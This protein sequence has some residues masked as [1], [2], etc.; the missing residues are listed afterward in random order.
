[1]N[2]SA[3]EPGVQSVQ[4][5]FDLLEALGAMGGEAGV[6]ELAATLRLPGPTIHRI[7]QTLIRRG[8]VMQLPSRRYSLG[9]GLIR[10]GDAAT[11]RL[12]AWAMPSLTRLAEVTK[13]TANL[14]VLDGDMATYVA[15]VPSP[16]Q[17]RMFTEVGRRVFPHSTGV[18]KALLAQTSDDE[19]LSIV[20]RTGM[21]SFTSATIGTEE[22]LL[23]ELKIIRQRGYAVDEGE[24]EVG[25]RCFAV[26]V[27]GLV[28]PAA[29]SVSG[30]EARVTLP[31]GDRTVQCLREAAVQLRS[32][33]PA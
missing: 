25:V 13:E 20:R 19:A 10:I 9:P 21:P 8:Y 6:G 32:A 16:H 11:R 28:I 31:L 14:A 26:P 12:S 5:A 24:Q 15:Q 22:D 23:V 4:R 2:V 7:L 17:M 29:V 18:G 3:P 33:V 27:P 1:M 30:P